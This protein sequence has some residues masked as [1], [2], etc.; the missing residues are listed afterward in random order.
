MVHSESR[1]HIRTCQAE[2]LPFASEKNTERLHKNG[3]IVHR[4]GGH[5]GDDGRKCVKD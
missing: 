2:P 1:R 5:L 4:N 3:H